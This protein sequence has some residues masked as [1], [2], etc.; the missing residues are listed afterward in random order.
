M[1]CTDAET[2]GPWVASKVGFKWVKGRG[3]AIGR[4]KDG[5]IVAGVIYEDYNGANVVCHIAIDKN[6]GS[7]KFFSIIFDYPFVRLGVKRITAV[8][9]Q[10]N[11]A[12]RKLVEHMGFEV[13][14]N[15]RDA[16]PDGD[17]LV[18]K[19]TAEQCRFT[20]ELPYDKVFSRPSR[21]P[22]KGVPEVTKRD[23]PAARK[24]FGSGNP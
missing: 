21:P 19:M 23:D 6:G 8:V 1:I 22:G 2:V 16:H 7:K 5:E 3:A 12:S 18:Y 15:L 4:V 14:A 11:R 17:L 13:E 10:N 9:A 24:G 20:K